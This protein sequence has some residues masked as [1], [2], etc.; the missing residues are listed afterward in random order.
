[1]KYMLYMKYIKMYLP[2]ISHEKYNYFI[3]IYL[4]KKV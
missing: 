4:Q 2:K 1:M 3:S